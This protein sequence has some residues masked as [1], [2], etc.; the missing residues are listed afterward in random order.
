VGVRYQVLRSMLRKR[1]ARLLPTNFDW[2]NLPE[3]GELPASATLR[4]D[5]CQLEDQWLALDYRLST[6]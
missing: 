4:I 1:F 6:N 5:H 2:A 3:L